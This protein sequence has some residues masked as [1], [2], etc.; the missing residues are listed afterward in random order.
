MVS[1]Q[2]TLTEEMQ[3]TPDLPRS[4]EPSHPLV[5]A[6]PLPLDARNRSLPRDPQQPPALSSPPPPGTGLAVPLEGLS[7]HARSVRPHRSG[8]SS[9]FSDRPRFFRRLLWAP[10]LPGASP[11][12]V[13]LPLPPLRLSLS[14]PPAEL[15][16]SQ[17][18]DGWHLSQPCPQAPSGRTWLRTSSAAPGSLSPASAH[19]PDGEKR[20]SGRARLSQWDPEPGRP[21]GGQTGSE[22]S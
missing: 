5:H 18:K 10:P 13:L 3:A 22:E 12:P 11:I 6:W 20:G 7:P 17:G 9:Y 21:S 15:R 1:G 4:L 8:L 16:T 19:S 14:G 2:L